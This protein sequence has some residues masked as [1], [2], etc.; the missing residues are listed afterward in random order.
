MR[1]KT[2]KAKRTLVGL[3][4]CGLLS[5]MTGSAVA[6]YPAKT[7]RMLVT[8]APGGA[9]DVVARILAQRLSE[10]IGQPVVVENKP[11]ANG[12]IA[13]E[14]VARAEPDGYTLLFAADSPIV[15]NPHV[16]ARMSYDPLKD[17]IPVASVATNE[18]FV[19]VN[20]NVPAKTLPELVEHARKANPPLLYASGGAGSLHQLGIEM[21]KQRASINLTH[22]PFRGGTPA[23]TA[24]LSGE[25]QVV[26]AGGSVT[27]LLQAGKLRGLAATGLK[28]SPLFPDLPTVNEFYPGY[29]LTRFGVFAPAG[30]PEAIVSK[31]R[32]E[33][34]NVLPELG[35]KFNVTGRLEPL[36]ISPGEFAALIRRDFEKNGK[37]VKDVGIKVE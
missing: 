13:G 11:G 18:F 37:I 31:L 25:T 24:T 17:L 6:Q 1:R 4:A 12:N 26:L 16:Y 14:Y 36:M 28:R 30:T 8:I 33:I 27:S 20:P 9:P 22:V 35:P 5:I 7:I 34:R 29:E 15:V 3:L 23:T 32:T 21:L 19:S 10:T 2:L